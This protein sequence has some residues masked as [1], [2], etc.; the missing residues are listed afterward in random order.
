MANH[1]QNV[2]L[3]VDDIP[4]NL[5]V[6]LDFLT[7]AGFEVLVAVDG[8]EAIEQVEYA[9]PD[10]IL[11]DVMMPNLDGFE[12]CRRLK[13]K[14]T[15]QD[16]PIIFMTA[17]SD[18]VNKI[19]GFELGAVDYITKPFQQVE[20]LARINV[21]LTLRKLQ[22]QLETANDQLER[23]IQER[24]AKLAEANT[25]LMTEVAERTRAEKMLRAIAQ[26]TASVT[27]EDFLQSLV[28][29]L[30]LALE[31]RRVLITE[32]ANEQRTTVRTLTFWNNG[33]FHP[34]T[35]YDIQ[36]TACEVTLKGQVTV[37]PQNLSQ[38]FSPPP[39]F[40]GHLADLEAYIGL[41]IWN[42][43][44][45]ILG[46][47]A[48][49]S[50]RPLIDEARYLDTVKIFAARA[51]AEL[52]RK[53]AEEERQLAHE[54][55]RQTNRAYSRFI[56]KEF[57]R[58]LDQKEI[59]ELKLGDQVQMEMTVMFADIRSFTSLSEQMTPQ[60]NFNFINA[61][62]KRVSPIIRQHGGFID[63]YIGDAVMALF[64]GQADTAVQAGIAMQQAVQCY[65]Q[66]RQ[67]EG[68]QPINI[69]VGLHTGNLMLGTIGE[70][71]RMEGTVISD[72]VNLAARM[73][74]LTKNYGAG[75]VMSDQT[76]L[77][78][79]NSD[80]YNYRFLDLVQV[81]GK[82]QP[83]SVFELFDGDP[84]A[85]ANLKLKTKT[86]F[87]EGLLIYHDQDFQAAKA[88]FTQV[89]AINPADKAA[90]I[91]LER[92]TTY[93][94]YGPPPDWQGVETLAEK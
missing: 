32:W 65:N 59:T 75:I 57:L 39:G 16:I 85:M 60:E 26:G 52:E 46:H 86:L 90:Q 8:Q 48:V 87:E 23:R 64:P 93:Q 73:E 84:P 68:Y 76:L 55:L 71:E 88:K 44:G 51:G 11:L 61:Y 13:K 17:L 40:E 34:N 67:Q 62:L 72:A 42:N 9:Q 15:T 56:P 94:I 38:H 10:I 49:F 83:V 12:T 43:N 18:T 79:A 47:L 25:M 14:L 91:Y 20:V 31:A 41:P 24:T 50:D 28:R 21:H 77:R 2:I 70:A 89:L 78:L 92:V 3:I 54:K 36:G 5:E 53:Y 19:T 30:G 37:Y 74:G 63:K 6:L 27:G 33:A 80:N 66:H 58:L 81:K 69:G 35:E 4:T 45:D 82:Q 22:Q 1:E 29:H 7:E